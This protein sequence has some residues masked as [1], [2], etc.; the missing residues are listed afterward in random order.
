MA[1][2]VELERTYLARFKPEGLETC[3]KTEIIDIYLPKSSK[4]PALRIRK[5]GTK[6]EIT[7]KEPTHEGDSSQQL[8]QTIPLPEGEFADLSLLEGKMVRKTRYL[9]EHEGRTAEIDVFQD[10]LEG[11]ALVDFEFTDA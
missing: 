4:H 2:T 8:E 9:Y 10:A 6:Y 7:K 11:L 3:E 5:N 1:N